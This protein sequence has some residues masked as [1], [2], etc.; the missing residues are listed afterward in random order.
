MKI[1]KVLITGASGYLA[2]FIVDRLQ[3]E[4]QLTLTDC[5]APGAD[6]GNLPFILGDVTVQSE[7]ESA[8]E[9]QDAV[10]HLVA[11]VRERFD[12]P[13]ALF[14]DVMVKGTWHVA[15]ACVKQGVQRLVNISSIAIC[16]PAPG[17]DLPYRVGEPFQFG[18]GG[19]YYALAKYL[20][21]QIGLAYHQAHGLSIIHLRPGVIAG[22]GLNPG[23]RAPED[24]K[25][26][27]F[28]YVD[29]R[30][31]A[32]AVERA[33]KTQEV[34]YGAYNVVAGRKDSRFDWRQTA[35]DL[36]YRP[37]HNWPEIPQRR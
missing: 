24:P 27:W 33:L 19:L 8:S 20:A 2:G 21:E 3:S 14:A 9:G 10:V 17:S 6:R 22:D 5:V 16:S 18:A 15:E 28:V 32:H 29:P 1:R 25:E 30:D 36:G 12:K 7:L 11:L 35:R 23:P 34:M 13:A 31:V 26:P 4:Y 37:E